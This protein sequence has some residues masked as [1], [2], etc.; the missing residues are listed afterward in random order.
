MLVV[1]DPSPVLAPVTPS[2][3]LQPTVSLCHRL[4][5]HYSPQESIGL[6]AN[7]GTIYAG[8]IRLLSIVSRGG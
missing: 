4:S 1:P 6:S 8:R 2:P 5:S 3:A 7:L